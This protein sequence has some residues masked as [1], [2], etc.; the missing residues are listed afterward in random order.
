MEMY[1]VPFGPHVDAR[2]V[3]LVLK[4]TQRGTDPIGQ[5][6]IT[7]VRVGVM[8]ADPIAHTCKKPDLVTE[9]PRDRSSQLPRTTPA[10]RGLSDR[11]PGCQDHHPYCTGDNLPVH[12]FNFVLSRLAGTHQD[13]P[14]STFTTCVET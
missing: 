5:D 7:H 10:D 2:D 14:R 9:L 13:G 11:S 12:T 8:T 3:E 6:P 4:R 1:L